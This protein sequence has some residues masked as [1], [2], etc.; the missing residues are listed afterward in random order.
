[1]SYS[2]VDLNIFDGI[3][4]GL[5]SHDNGVRVL[6]RVRLRQFVEDHGHEKCEEMFAVLAERD[7]NNKELIK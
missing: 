5:S 1:M 4:L 6:S 3:M 7:K 2:E